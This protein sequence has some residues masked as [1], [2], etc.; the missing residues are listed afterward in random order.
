MCTALNFR[1]AS[2]ISFLLTD[3]ST[4]RRAHRNFLNQDSV[5]DVI[6]FHNPPSLD[7]LISL[8]AAAREA[9]RRGLFVWQEILLYMGHALLHA[10]GFDDT[11]PAARDRM[12]QAEFTLLSQ[13][14]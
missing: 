1:G 9:R 5:T 10:T 2:E 13:V 4:I 11:T 8:D 7:I 6:T 3:D 14:V 12:R